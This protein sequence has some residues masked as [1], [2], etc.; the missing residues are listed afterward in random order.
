MNKEQ[1]NNYLLRPA[2]LRNTRN[3]IY[4]IRGDPNNYNNN[5]FTENI[6]I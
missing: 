5:N 1:F 6:K 3:M 4:D 2:P